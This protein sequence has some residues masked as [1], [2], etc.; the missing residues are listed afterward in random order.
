MLVASLTDL[1][2]IDYREAFKQTSF[3]TSGPNDDFLAEQ[4]FA[5]VN[6]F[7][8]HNQK[9]EKLVPCEPFFEDGWVYTVKVE[10]KSQ[11][12]IDA[13]TNSEANLIRIERNKMIAECDWTQLPDSPLN[14]LQKADWIEY[15]QALRDITK[16][17]GFPWEI[18]W[19][20]KPR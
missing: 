8:T 15:R 14:S 18:E 13:E 9:T 4:G 6:S 11:Y 16:Q 20:I 12:E 3:P 1:K 10:S 17:N 2:P 7:K 5:K 19:P